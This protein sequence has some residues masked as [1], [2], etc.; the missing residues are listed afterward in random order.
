MNNIKIAFVVLHYMVTKDTVE[1]VQS[2]RKWIDTESYKIV[3][4]ENGSPNN[5]YQEL[6]EA[7]DN[8]EDV[9]VLHSDTNLGFAKGNNLGFMYA[10][11]ELKAEFIV[12]MNNDILLIENGF[13][14]KTVEEYRK[15]GFA[16]LGPMV[17]TADGR[18]DSN[19]LRKKGMSAEDAKTMRDGLKNKLFFAQH[20]LERFYVALKKPVDVT[21]KYRV[22][23]HIERQ[24]NIC[25]HGC[26][27]IFAKPFIDKFDGLDENTFLYV[28][29]DILY[30]HLQK[31]GLKTVYLPG[32]HIFHKEDCSTNAVQQTKK[33]KRIFIYSHIYQSLQR[34]IEVLEEK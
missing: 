4:V 24:E 1:C 15:S 14:S 11:R 25:L 23:N 18:Y 2:I 16:V 12:L 31:A 30:A 17:L 10:K 22:S 3:V 26:C 8:Q 7:F 33:E 5:S 28:E 34:L 29:E 6:L 19:P 27:M 13:Y 9:V 21:A 20:R 32:L